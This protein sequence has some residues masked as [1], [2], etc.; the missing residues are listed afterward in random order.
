M[1]VYR[2]YKY[3]GI[4]QSTTFY[5]YLMR[6]TRLFKYITIGLGPLS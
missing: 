5:N 2:Q 6:F 3:R 1:S 4:K